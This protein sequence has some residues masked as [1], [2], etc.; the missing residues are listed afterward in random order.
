[1]TNKKPWNKQR[2]IIFFG[3]LALILVIN[4]IFFVDWN[5]KEQT[6]EKEN[7]TKIEEAANTEGN[8]TDET[9]KE[10]ETKE[11]DS[12]T[13]EYKDPLAET[14]KA[15]TY[16]YREHI[17]PIGKGEE[18]PKEQSEL[19]KSELLQHAQNAEYVEIMEKMNT[20][21]KTY[22]FSE[23]TN[24]DIAGIYHDVNLLYSLKDEE[25][26]VRYGNAVATSKTPEM[27]VINTLFSDHFDRRQILED[28]T[29]ISP[30][31]YNYFSI[32]KPRLYRNEHEA[33]EEQTFKHK[34]IVREIFIM[35]DQ[36]NTVYAF[37][38]TIPQLDGGLP[39]TAYVW[40]DLFGNIGFYGM[41]VPDD[42][43]TYE[44]TLEWWAQHDHL[45][46]NLEKRREKYYEDLGEK[47]IITD[48]QIEMWFESG[49]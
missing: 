38:I 8:M 12:E 14:K 16:L 27:L 7:P 28:W 9:G 42:F 15:I 31:G 4:L 22:R 19:L 11:Q 23:G 30:I 40:E 32:Q 39:I 33:E 24:L 41:Y 34:N 17:A 48:E 47:G 37:D 43:K 26:P 45:F 36:L 10:N 1:M 35:K 13:E 29:S 49:Y 46:D 21:I 20:L 5:S 6:E 44:Q 18:Y 3:V 25:D 2:S